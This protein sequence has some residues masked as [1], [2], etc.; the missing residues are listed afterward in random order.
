MES[1][2][3]YLASL[4]RGENLSRADAAQL[5]DAGI[6]QRMLGKLHDD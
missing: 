4:M 3:D 2:R 1:L 5:L 6:G